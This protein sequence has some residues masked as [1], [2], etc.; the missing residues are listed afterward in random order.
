MQS[1]ETMAIAKDQ[2]ILLLADGMG[3]HVHG[4]HASSSV[5]AA[6][7][8]IPEQIFFDRDLCVANIRKA[9]ANL[10]RL[11]DKTPDARGMGSTL[12]GMTLSGANLAIFNIGD[13]PVS[14]GQVSCWSCR[15]ET[16]RV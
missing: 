10:Y 12:V 8:S 11:M 13:S 6:L 14:T 3:G 9:N 7:A 16:R 15:S 4:A 1:P 2:C 5:V